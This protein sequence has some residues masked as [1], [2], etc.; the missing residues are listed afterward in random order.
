M[1][2][3]CRI[4]GKPAAV[5]LSIA[6]AVARPPS[7]PSRPGPQ[8]P[9]VSIA[10]ATR[11]WSTPEG[12][13]L[14]AAAIVSLALGSYRLRANRVRKREKQLRTMIER[15]AAELVQTRDQ[16]RFASQAKSDLLAQMTHQARGPLH[17]IIEFSSLL[18]A[19]GTP[20]QRETLENIH[21]SAQH[22]LD[23]LNEALVLIQPDARGGPHF[24][25]RIAPG[26]P[27]YRVMVI[28]PEPETRVAL[29]ALLAS[30]GFEVRA[31]DNGRGVADVI[32]ELHPQFIWI[33]FGTANTVELTIIRNIRSL[34]EAGNVKIAGVVP[35]SREYDRQQMLAAGL[36]DFIRWP[37]GQGEI[38]SCLSRHLGFRYTTEFSAPESRDEPAEALQAMAL[39]PQPLRTELTEAVLSLDAERIEAAVWRICELDFRLGRELARR[40]ERYSYTEIFRAIEAGKTRRGA[41]MEAGS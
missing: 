33:G 10:A 7:Q 5:A 38:L 26:Q 13:L 18:R 11:R 14:A 41:G 36:D 23:V 37:C 40:V 27:T 20:E 25:A 9:P 12:G 4:L 16:A 39:L 31:A 34:P 2:L 8:L 30:A 19:S 17:Q 15:R 1:T 6:F 35:I 22:A 3:S 28:E 32:T 29:E 21:R 24:V